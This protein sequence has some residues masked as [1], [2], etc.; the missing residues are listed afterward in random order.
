MS[1][2]KVVV[3]CCALMGAHAVSAEAT[4]TVD[5]RVVVQHNP[6]DDLIGRIDSSVPPDPY[7]TL[8]HNPPADKTIIN[9]LSIPPD[10]YMTILHNP[11]M[12]KTAQS[13]AK[14]NPPT[15]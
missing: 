7:R 4:S 11:P 12:Y 6:P 9:D 3:L 1:F 14:H 13:D 5:G 8:E 10:P 2:S 15:Y